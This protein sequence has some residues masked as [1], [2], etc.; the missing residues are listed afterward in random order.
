VAYLD[1]FILK[2]GKML[3]GRGSMTVYL[4]NMI[5]RLIKGGTTLKRVDVK[6]ES[7]KLQFVYPTCFE[8]GK[9][10]ELVVC[11]QNLL[12]PKCRY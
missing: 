9:P 10:I 5:F 1:E 12:Q 4:N 6:L 2:P 7:P 8:A 11:G 3:F